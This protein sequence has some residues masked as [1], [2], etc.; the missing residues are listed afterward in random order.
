MRAVRPK[1]EQQVSSK[2]ELLEE[3]NFYLGDVLCP[4]LS[5]SDLKSPG[6]VQNVVLEAWFQKFIFTS[7]VFSM[8]LDKTSLDEQV[9]TGTSWQLS[10]EEVQVDL[11]LARSVFQ[12]PDDCEGWPRNWR[13]I[14]VLVLNYAHTF[15]KNTRNQDLKSKFKAEY[16]ALNYFTLRK[17]ILGLHHEEL[18][19]IPQTLYEKSGRGK[20]IREDVRLGCTTLLDCKFEW[21][22]WKK[23][24]EATLEDPRK[25]TALYGSLLWWKQRSACEAVRHKLSTSESRGLVST[26]WP[27]P[28]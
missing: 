19:P 27:L 25:L 16:V 21:R 23:L 3:K 5:L 14:Q 17:F 26:F 1:T 20:N 8:T 10:M 24:V 22:L 4:H 9:F 13:R 2:M 28:A 18:F 6:V 15:S 12:I 11:Q 7:F